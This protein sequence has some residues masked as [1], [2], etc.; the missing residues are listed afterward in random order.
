MKAAGPIIAVIA[1][2]GV[3]WALYRAWSVWR[4]RFGNRDSLES[5]RE[6]ALLAEL[7]KASSEAPET[8]MVLDPPPRPKRPKPVQPPVTGPETVPVGDPTPAT[9]R[10]PAAS[11]PALLDAVGRVVFFL[12]KI[13]LNDHEVLSRVDPAI[14]LPGHDTALPR[15]TLDFVVCRRDFTP[16]AIIMVQRGDAE[17]PLRERVIAL[18]SQRGMKVLRWKVG[19]LPAR[20]SVRDAVL[21]TG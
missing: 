21:G 17:E 3:A 18:L 14:F 7:R 2:L 5:S 16:A 1:L 9:P 12:L 10:M 11:V 8:V 6:M 15:A 13:E 4:E 20:G 19:A